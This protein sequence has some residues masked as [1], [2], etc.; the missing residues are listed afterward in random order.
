MRTAYLLTTNENSP[1][2]QFSKNILENIGFT[3]V[4]YKAVPHND[5]VLS[6]KISMMN[7]YNIICNSNDSW[8][9]VFEDDINVVEPILLDEIIQYEK[10]SDPFFY[11]GC[12]MMDGKMN[13][14]GFIVNNNP[15]TSIS[16]GVRGLH[17][18]GISKK[19]ATELL[20][21]AKNSRERY[22]DCILELFSVIHPANIV[23]YD[24]ISPQ[25]SG[26]RGVLFQDRHQFPSTI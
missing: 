21:F 1:I 12:C 2:A 15:V 4:F 20:D 26:H 17:G 16:G 18:I 9:Y 19:G 22:M 13:S 11:L 14:T 23:R 5:K 10:I 24:L 8:G 7:I 6:N 3:V 25:E